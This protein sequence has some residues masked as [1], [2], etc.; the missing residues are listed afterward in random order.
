MTCATFILKEAKLFETAP[1]ECLNYYFEIQFDCRFTVPLPLSPAT[2]AWRASLKAMTM[3]IMCHTTVSTCEHDVSL[4][5]L[6][7]ENI[8][9]FITGDHGKY[10]KI[11]LH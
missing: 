3:I 10:H 11:L 8:M 4:Q 1:D 5:L 6:Y 9:A 2:F 7:I